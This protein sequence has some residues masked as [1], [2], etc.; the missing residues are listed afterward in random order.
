ML[1]G[2]GIPF[3]NLRGD[4]SF[5]RGIISLSRMVAYGG[6]LGISADGWLNPGQDRIEIDGTLA[7]AYAL[8]SVL[9]NFPVLGSLL[10]GGEGQGLFAARFHLG[11]SNDNPTVT[12]NPE[13]AALRLPG[14]L[15]HLFDP[16][17]GT[18]Q[19]GA[20]VPPRAT[21]PSRDGGH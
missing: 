15:R 10:M 9:G 14:L 12:V 19:P 4:V 16:F 1:S 20:C 3:T 11:G 8:N 2:S 7:P 17:G 18:G 13:Q 21:A 5:S 6:A